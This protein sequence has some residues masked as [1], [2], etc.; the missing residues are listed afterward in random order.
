MI[1]NGLKAEEYGFEPT[2]VF[3]SAVFFGVEN[4]SNVHNNC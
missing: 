2:I 4:A 3:R 1:Y